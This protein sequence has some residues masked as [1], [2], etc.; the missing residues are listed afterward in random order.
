MLQHSQA[1]VSTGLISKLPNV[2][3]TL[4]RSFSIL[5]R[6]PDKCRSS[7][8]LPFPDNSARRYLGNSVT[9]SQGNSARQCLVKSATPSQGSRNSKSAIRSQDSS[10]TMCP[11]N[12]VTRWREK[13][14][15]IPS[16]SRSIGAN[17][18]R[19]SSRPMMDRLVPRI[20]TGRRR[21]LQ[22]LLDHKTLTGHPRL[23][24]CRPVHKTLT[25]HLKELPLDLVVVAAPVMVHHNSSLRLTLME[26]QELF[27]SPPIL[28]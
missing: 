7:S 13:N 16:A 22:S 5:C 26:R 15:A 1:A 24:P 20:P 9:P 28:F 17:N 4:L 6:L 14:A 8:A 11:D 12:S 27:L 2:K 23:P 3:V 19:N 18:A 25:E 21:L 10:A